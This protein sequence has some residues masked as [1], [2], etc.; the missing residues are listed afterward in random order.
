M[1]KRLDMDKIAGALG[2]ERRGAV[3]AHGGFIGALQLVA[4]IQERLKVPSGGGR[5][6]DP[7]LT[8]R[9][10]VGLSRATYGRLKAISDSIRK[11]R[12]I[13]LSPMQVAALL[14]EKAADQLP[15]DEELLPSY[16]EAKVGHGAQKH[17]R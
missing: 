17:P 11:T 15:E 4:E 6:T 12:K 9:R 14:L 16:D 1:K 2:A 8:E 3:R 13:S 10:L 5:P 7:D